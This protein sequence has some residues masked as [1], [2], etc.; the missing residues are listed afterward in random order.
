M[1]SLRA[2]GVGLENEGMGLQFRSCDS[3]PRIWGLGWDRVRVWAGFKTVSSGFPQPINPKKSRTPL[4]IERPQART[5][6]PY[7][8]NPKP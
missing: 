4:N 2:A 7:L 6:K 8:L 1:V 5:P 3:G